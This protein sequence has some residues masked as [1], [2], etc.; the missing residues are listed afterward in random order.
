M[1][2]VLFSRY[3]SRRH[4]HQFGHGEVMNFA[5]KRSVAFGLI[6]SLLFGSTITLTGCFGTFR[7][8]QAVWE[9][10]EEISSNKFV[11]WLVFLGLTALPIYEGA[12]LIDLFITN[13]LEFW[14]GGSANADADDDEPKRR[15]VELRDGRKAVVEHE[16]DKRM[17]VTML[18]DGEP[19]SEF[20]LDGN[21][22]SLELRDGTGRL[23]AA[24]RDGAN[25]GVIVNNSGGEVIDHAG[26]QR[27]ESLRDRLRDKGR[28][29]AVDFMAERRERQRA[30]RV[31]P[32]V[33]QPTQI[34]PGLIDAEG[35][36]SSPSVTPE[37]IQPRPDT[38][39]EF[40]PTST[41]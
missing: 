32:A 24:A 21:D 2:G 4:K 16:G 8:T 15:E 27:V 9:F 6:L 30:D 41:P 22:E 23:I 19:E 28:Q 10:N 14:S 39:T 7:L 38:P 34:H 5:K 11:Q 31:E 17:R 18:R 37:P 3:S 12:I 29:G 20:V 33:I 1:S 35:G 13:A 36:P 25:G 40:G 26:P